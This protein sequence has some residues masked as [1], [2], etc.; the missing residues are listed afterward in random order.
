MWIILTALRG[1]GDQWDNPRYRAILL[2]WQA[3]ASG[4]ALACFRLRPDAWL[5]R[6]FL[7]E[8]I[9]LAFFTQWYLNRYFEIGGQIPFRWMVALIIAGSLIVLVG[10][11]LWDRYQRGKPAA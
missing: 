2:L 4:Y 5:A 6:I 3:L 10:G 1:G 8:G 11:G 9:F 7:I